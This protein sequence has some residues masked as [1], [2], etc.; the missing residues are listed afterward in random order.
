MINFAYFTSMRYYLILAITFFLQTPSILAQPIITSF[1]PI[2]GVV[3]TSVTISG[4]GFNTTTANNIVIFGAT[5]A[6]VT[7]ATA[8]ELTVTVPTGATYAPVTVLNTST[9][10]L[11]YTQSNFSPTFY[12]VKDGITDADFSSM[13]DFTTGMG[14]RF[15]SIGDQDGDGRA[16]LAV[17]NVISSSVSVFRNTG[18]DGIVNYTEKVDLA[19]GYSP[20]SVSLGDLDGDGKIDLVVANE[21]SNSISVFHNTSSVGTINYADKIDITTGSKPSSFSIGD[22]DGD[23]K[24]D[25][26]VANNFSNTV[27]V[28][29]NTGSVGT[30]SY[31]DKVDITAGS[32]PSSISIGDLDGDGKADLAVTNFGS[33][34]VSVFRNTGIS[35]TISYADKVDID[36]DLNPASVS[37]G[38]LDGDGKA[39]LAVAN[40]GNSTISV[41]RNASSAGTISY[42][43]KVDINT[44]LNP[45]SVSIGELDGDGKADLAVSNAGSRNVSVFR[46][47]SSA[48][49]IIY[50]DKVD[51]DTGVS[52]YSVSIGDQDGDSKADLVVANF[53]S[54]TVSIIRNILPPPTITGFSPQSGPV[55]TTVTITGTGFNTTPA[56]NIVIFGATTAAVTTATTNQLT[57]TIPTGATYGPLTVLNTTTGLLAYSQSSFTPTFFPTKGNITEGDFDPKIDFTTGSQPVSVAI[58]DLDGDGKADIAVANLGNG[59]S[60]FRNTSSAGAISYAA[61]LDFNTGTSPSSV[62]IGDLDGDGKS[63]LAVANAGSRN[64]SIFHNASSPGTISFVGKV[65]FTNGSNR[66]SSIAIGD[67][68]LDG[69]AD[70]A[71]ANFEGNAVSVFR[72]TSSIGTINYAAKLDFIVEASIYRSISICDLDNDGKADLAALNSGGNS[73]SIFRNTGSVGT[74]NF[75]DK[76]DLMTGINSTPWSICIGDLDGDHKTDLAV[77]NKNSNSVSVFRNTSS[78]SGISFAGKED[79]STGTEPY[80]ISIGDLDGDGKADIAVTNYGNSTVSVFRNTASAGIISYTAKVDYATG[81][82]PF[83]VAIGDLDGD[84]KADLAVANI[85]SNTVSIIRNNPLVT[86]DLVSNSS[87][88]TIYPNPTSEK[89]YIDLSSIELGKP[90]ELKITDFMGRSIHKQKVTG[91][92]TAEADIATYANGY[93]FIRIMQEKKSVQ[94]KFV[95]E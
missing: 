61:K 85:G 35:G 40:S 68:D 14:P 33:N 83:S 90:V 12:P 23:G 55:G 38:D 82:E 11:A 57:V 26:A 2:S 86:G 56:N 21:G 88:V 45:A 73:V 67:L 65:D 92:T 79:F 18:S 30:I 60:V 42:P 41:F 93:Y 81:S 78:V 44:G 51:F 46:N 3:G 59:I 5:A 54:N 72:N 58:G 28:L 91:G 63:D 43:D 47:N 22:L 69:K 50:S 49:T 34:S 89:L 19:T 6:T 76:V 95:K 17:V 8:T 4:T 53:G 20:Q 15:V 31:A 16:D 87:T 9:G 74:I 80:S 25:L 94:L 75:A 62:A 48:G 13:V 1:T 64:V 10:L 66:P 77:S 36:T 39:D 52:P 37:I 70:I 24:A 84:G 27:S 7:A 32:A 29:R 71:V